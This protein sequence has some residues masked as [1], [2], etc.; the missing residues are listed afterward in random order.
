MKTWHWCFIVLLI[1]SFL[2]YNHQT[3][4]I[5]TRLESI[6][7]SIDTTL[8]VIGIAI[9]ATLERIAESKESKKPKVATL[10]QIR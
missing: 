3:P 4:P 2:F 8:F 1:I 9:V 7:D 5:S 6:L 10:A